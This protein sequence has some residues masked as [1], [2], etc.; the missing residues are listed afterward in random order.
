MAHISAPFQ[1][2]ATAMSYQIILN[3]FSNFW[4]F[5]MAPILGQTPGKE[6]EANMLL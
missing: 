5:T 3:L 2:I 6:K 1:P 4:I